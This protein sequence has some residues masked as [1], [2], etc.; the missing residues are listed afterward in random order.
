MKKQSLASYGY[1]PCRL[2]LFPLVIV[3]LI[4]AC[5]LVSRFLPI[6]YPPF[7]NRF[8]SSFRIPLLVQMSTQASEGLMHPLYS[9]FN[10]L[11]I[12]SADNRGTPDGLGRLV[13]YSITLILSKL[14]FSYLLLTSHRLPVSLENFKIVTLQFWMNFSPGFFQQIHL[15][16]QEKRY[17]QPSE[18]P[19]PM[20]IPLF[21][22]QILTVFISS[23]ILHLLRFWIVETPGI[24][25]LKT[26]KQVSFQ[27]KD[28][29]RIYFYFFIV[30][31]QPLYWIQKMNHL[32][33]SVTKFFSTEYEK[34]K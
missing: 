15:N 28:T 26:R 19:F 33:C 25:R 7:L 18:A 5:L 16:L 2:L 3:A 27:V 9:L 4:N 17:L 21:L 11:A 31:L 6:T 29:G 20:K 34:K 1:T 8:F 30:V 24:K 13:K 10:F 12:I 22:F 14:L 32:P 23:I